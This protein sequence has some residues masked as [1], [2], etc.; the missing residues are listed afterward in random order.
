MEESGIADDVAFIRGFEGTPPGFWILPEIVNW[1]AF[2]GEAAAADPIPGDL[3]LRA[4]AELRQACAEASFALLGTQA[5]HLAATVI[6]A[7]VYADPVWFSLSHN[8][9]EP[10]D[11][12]A[13]TIFVLNF[14]PWTRIRALEKSVRAR[15]PKPLAVESV[16]EP[17]LPTARG[18]SGSELA[19][20]NDLIRL[21]QDNPLPPDTK[22]NYRTK[23]CA[24]YGLAV[25]AFERPWANAIKLSPDSHWGKAGRRSS[26]Q[27]T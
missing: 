23:F 27:R 10:D 13:P 26:N 15:W 25:R 16:A 11:E 9:I 12:L 24:H 8:S 22:K 7:T 14:R 21:M 3:I 19:C 18:G 6:P 4:E 5:D 2:G 1:I 17:A 20:Q